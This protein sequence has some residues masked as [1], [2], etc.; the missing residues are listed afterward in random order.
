VSA[1]AVVGF[2]IADEPDAW[3]AV[4]F[5]VDGDRAQI[6]TIGLRLVGRSGGK[7]ITSWTWHGLAGDGPLDGLIT[8]AATAPTTMPAAHA[9]GATVLDHVVV[10]TPRLD[11]T[12]TAFEAR[13]LAVR[14]VRHT[15]QYGPAFRQVFFR[16]GETIIELIGPDEPPADDDRPAHFYG[17][18]FTVADLDATAR[19]LGDGVGRIKDA[20]QP[21]RRITTLRH[22]RYDVSVPIAL[23]SA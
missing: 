4:G 15:D 23:M 7:R 10:V 13:G 17:L 3:R 21:G 16:G 1:P 18:A 8:H 19:A 14:R 5:T 6:G 2:E 11:R 20:V 22:D 9:N 12:I